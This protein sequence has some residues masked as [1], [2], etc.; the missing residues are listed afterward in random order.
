[1]KRFFCGKKAF[2]LHLLFS[3]KLRKV[4]LHC[5]T[6]HS[7]RGAIQEAYQGNKFD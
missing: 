4:S 3:K 5:E 7:I 2:I 1:M 6:K